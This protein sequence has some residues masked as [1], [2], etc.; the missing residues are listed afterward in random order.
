MMHKYECA[1]LLS[2]G[3]GDAEHEWKRLV[4]E[5][6]YHKGSP[7]YTPRGEYAPIDP[8]EPEHVEIGSVYILA[9]SIVRG[10]KTLD[11][12]H[13]LPEWM[14]EPL[15]E[16]LEALALDHWRGERDD[17][18]ERRAEARRDDD[19]LDRIERRPQAGE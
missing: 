5:Y 10:V 17:A 16:Q 7:A 1:L 15:T 11:A 18:M 2:I 19:M 4:V 3:P 14:V 12:R 6:A 8:P 13:P 9:E